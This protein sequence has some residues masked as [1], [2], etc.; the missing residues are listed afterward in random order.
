MALVSTSL[1]WQGSPSVAAETE[2]L[3]SKGNAPI[4]SLWSRKSLST[5][6]RTSVHTMASRWGRMLVGSRNRMCVA[7]A[8]A[9]VHSLRCKKRLPSVKGRTPVHTS[10]SWGG[11]ILVWCRKRLFHLR[12]SSCEHLVIC[13]FESHSADIWQNT[14]SGHFQRQT[15]V[16]RL[17]VWDSQTPYIISGGRPD[18]PLMCCCWGGWGQPAVQVLLRHPCCCCCSSLLVLLL[19]N[20]SAFASA[21]VASQTVLHF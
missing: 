8:S 7:M 20:A 19:N 1:S 15:F 6:D 18:Q 3:V 12:Q 11:V 13:W 10:A 17:M 5:K 4:Y 2:A 9:P 14:R 21:V 16:K